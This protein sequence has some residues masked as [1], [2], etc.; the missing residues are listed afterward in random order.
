MKRNRKIGKVPAW[1]NTI[2]S[3]NS[4]RLEKIKHAFETDASVAVIPAKSETQATTGIKLR[5]AAYCRVSTG[6]EAQLT[7]YAVQTSYYTD[8][9]CNNPDWTLVDIYADEGLSGTSTNKRTEFLRMIED[10]KE[11]KI[12][13]IITKDVS[14][15]S[16]NTV[17]CL[18]YVRS[19]L[20]LENPVSI[21]FEADNF[22]TEKDMSEEQL[23]IR[24]MVAQ[25]DSERKSY[26]IKW[27]RRI[28]FQQGIA[29]IPTHCLL[30]YTKDAD[31]A[32]VIEK[33]QAKVIRFI[34]HSYL[35]GKSITEIAAQ[36]TNAQ[37]PTVT[38]KA[39]WRPAA[40]S[41]ILHNEKYK[42]AVLMQKSYTVNCFSHQVRKNK[43]QLAQYYKED[44]HDPIIPPSVWN[45][46]QSQLLLRRYCRP[47]KSACKKESVI[48][49]VKKG[50]FAGFEILNPNWTQ[51]ETAFYLQTIRNEE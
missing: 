30:G 20:S 9:I 16:R 19:L 12:D 28:L 38:N 17:D 37:V 23:I 51:H 5:V 13:L 29:L 40:V 41:S 33:K 3:K 2:K 42:G 46:V 32:V 43:G 36:L 34:Y 18:I 25:A 27:S 11:G 21:W 1:E 15:F 50:R 7:S 24:A 4:L 10:C 49:L 47:K 14:R 22:K 45:E 44:N 8:L 6:N 48:K 39:V 26:R 31:G 35:D